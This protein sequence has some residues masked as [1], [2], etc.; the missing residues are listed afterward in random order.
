VWRNGVAL[1]LNSR[2]TV[3]TGLKLITVVSGNKKGQLLV[4]AEPPDHSKWPSLLLL[5]P[6]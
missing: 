3:P 4:L 1:D 5:T 6:K 2:T